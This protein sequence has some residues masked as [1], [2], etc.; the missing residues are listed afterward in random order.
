MDLQLVAGGTALAESESPDG[1][2]SPRVRLGSGS[3]GVALKALKHPG[4]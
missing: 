2:S 3:I 1:Q 4:L